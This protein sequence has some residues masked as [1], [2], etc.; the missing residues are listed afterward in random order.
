MVR[1][2]ERLPPAPGRGVTIAGSAAR[3]TFLEFYGGAGVV[4]FFLTIVVVSKCENWTARNTSER[5]IFYRAPTGNNKLWP[6]IGDADFR[7]FGRWLVG[8]VK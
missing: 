3:S 6:S 8:A 4:K 2:S 7:V 1:S 5:N